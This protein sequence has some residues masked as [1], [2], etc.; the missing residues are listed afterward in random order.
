MKQYFAENFRKYRTLKNISQT[1]LAQKLGVSGQAVSKWEC[2]LSY[3]D[4]EMLTE[5]ADLFEISVDA[6]LR[7]NADGCDRLHE[8]ADGRMELVQLPDDDVVRVVQCIGRRI[9]KTGMDSDKRM[10]LTVDSEAME[11]LAKTCNITICFEGRADIKGN[12]Y[13]ADI[14]V[15]N[16]INCGNV[17]ADGDIA[18]SG[19][20]N[21]GNINSE[22]SV[23]IT[24]GVNSGYIIS[25][26]AVSV[27][28]DMNCGDAEADSIN[29]KSF[30]AD[31][32]SC[33]IL[34]CEGDLTVKGVLQKK[35]D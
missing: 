11:A 27:S 30:S 22:D 2:A 35:Q 20:V 15:S 7:E 29:C 13:G 24:G 23:T 26:D 10:L 16:G 34:K 21:C 19:G 25:K 8:N 3:P 4:V 1:E 6:L 17:Y 33:R 12:L 9:V 5:I 31:K 18:V 28:G 14:T 32:V